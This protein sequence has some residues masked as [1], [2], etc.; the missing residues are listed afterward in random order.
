MDHTDGKGG[1][2][3]KQRADDQ[4]N[5]DAAHNARRSK[6]DCAAVCVEERCDGDTSGIS[7]R[8]NPVKTDLIFSAIKA[9]E[10]HWREE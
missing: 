5:G 10:A 3:A 9:A 4:Q 7:E 1:A 8:Y 6:A 2:E